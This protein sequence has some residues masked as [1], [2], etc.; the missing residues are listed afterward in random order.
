MSRLHF[1]QDRLHRTREILL[2]PVCRMI[3]LLDSLFLVLLH[4]AL[5]RL[6]VAVID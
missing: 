5:P 6:I 2:D 4:S 3:R 1:L